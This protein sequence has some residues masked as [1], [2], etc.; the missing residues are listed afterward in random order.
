MPPVS[1]IQEVE[2]AIPR[3]DGTIPGGPSYVRYT[4]E[5][6]YGAWP[7]HNYYNCPTGYDCP[8]PTMYRMDPYG[9]QTRWVDVSAGGPKNSTWRALSS[10]KWLKVTPDHGSVAQDGTTD[11]RVK[12]SVDWSQLQ[13]PEGENDYR[14]DNAT[15]H[16][17]ASDGSNV[18]IAC[19]VAIP[20][21]PDPEFA[22]FVQGDG[23]VV[24]EAGHFTSNMT[25]DGY[26]FEEIE[27]YGRSV[28]GLE[29]FPSTE[30]N[31]T[32]GEG[33]SLTYDF[34][35]TGVPATPKEWDGKVN[36]TVQLGPTFNFMIGKE[37]AFGLQLDDSDVLEIHPIPPTATF[38]HSGSTPVDWDEVV[39]HEIR[40][41]TASFDLRDA[42]KAGKHS[43][44]VYGMTAGVLIERIWIDFGG[45]L[46]RGYSYFGPPESGRV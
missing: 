5:N 42:G 24:M 14:F 39:T 31:F 15:V 35:A 2:P 6:S 1:F 43:L 13:G 16:F 10:A 21:K 8:D 29:M 22:G 36:V 12:I 30:R 19:P 41:A 23:Y 4:V 7:G 46:S 45:I 37:L 32:A 33:P 17:S 18:T 26:A 25:A 34:W 9:Q 38:D 44:T 27:A 20:R 28:S 3:W 40:N 11:T